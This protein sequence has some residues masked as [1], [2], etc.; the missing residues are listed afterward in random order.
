MASATLY[1]NGRIHAQ[2]A[3]AAT[4]LLVD[5]GRIAWIGTEAG[6]TQ[7]AG[8]P[9]VDLAGNWLAPGF[10]DGHVH[11]ADTGLALDADLAGATSRGELSARLQSLTAHDNI[12][13][14]HGWDDS[15]WSQSPDWT[16]LPTGIPVYA[17]RVDL[18]TAIVNEALFDK[19]P[20]LAQA[21]G[22]RGNGVVQ[23]DAHELARRTALGLCSPEERLR[24][25]Q[26]ALGVFAAN[27]VVAVHEMS[28]PTVSS[29]AEAE[30]LA[31]WLRTASSHPEVFVWWGEADGGEVAAALDAFGAGGDL[32]ID[33]SIGSRTASVSS[34]YVDA[35]G[36][37]NRYLSDDQVQRHISTAAR[38]GR[39]TSFHAIGDQAMASLVLAWRS[40]AAEIGGAAFVGQQH[41][42]E[43]AMMLDRAQ[44]SL[45]AELNIAV[46][47][48][49]QFEARWGGPDGMYAHRLGARRSVELLPLAS[50]HSAGVPL[51][52]G[53]DAPVTDVNP[54]LTL[55]A[56]TA[57]RTASESL[58]P[59][60][61]FNAATRTAYRR[62]G[63]LA[64][65]IAVGAEANFAVWSVPEFQPAGKTGGRWSADQRS[66]VLELPELGAAL[67]QCLF[68]VRAGLPIYT[69]E[70]WT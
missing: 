49:P 39:R 19:V 6:C 11:L 69:R 26:R 21:A 33:G 40:V 48:Q 29:R 46:S 59:R 37:G 56:A 61:A 34:G 25:A 1:R 44:I 10:V 65:E 41:Q 42:V 7:F 27:G 30:Q 28:G 51:V 12:L 22:W 55:R 60:A 66:G 62:A 31:T 52:L 8:L 67:P 35:P 16:D 20:G 18:H 58:S 15:E 23:G 43:H 36:N 64:G 4:A 24:Q 63:R 17:S 2:T 53:S 47:A 32:F 5:D 38:H 13:L 50:L 68:T 54:W 45:L 57:M 9:T 70:G 14:A 3:P